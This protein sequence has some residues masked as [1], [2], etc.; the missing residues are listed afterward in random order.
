MQLSV[1][2]FACEFYIHPMKDN[3]TAKKANRTAGRWFNLL[4]G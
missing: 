2:D 3:I 4:V 1:L